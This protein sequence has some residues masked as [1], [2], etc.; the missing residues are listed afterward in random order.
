MT[1]R[2]LVVDDVSAN[3][4]LLKVKLENEYFT[5]ATASSGM[6]ALEAAA[7]GKPDIILLDVMMPGMDGF[8]T[9]CRLKAN[10]DTAHI[11]VIMVTALSEQEYRVRGL[12]AGADDFLTKPVDTLALIA[13]VRSLVRI[14]QMMD[15]LRV[16][17]STSRELG[18][19]RDAAEQPLEIGNG[20]VLLVS[21]AA[22]KAA[23][24]A[25][26]IGSDTVVQIEADGAKT[27]GVASAGSFDVIV[28]DA[29]S[30]GFDGLRLC[31][32]LRGNDAT[33]HVPI[34]LIISGS[35]RDRLVRA[36]EIGVF[37]YVLE[38]VD[39]HEFLARTR[40]QIKR[41][42]Y[43][44][45][46]RDSYHRSVELAITDELTG[47]FNRHYLKSHMGELMRRSADGHSVAVAILDIDFFKKI[48]DTYGHMA[49]D[50]I[51]QA[52]AREIGRNIRGVDL[53][54]RLGGEEFVVVMPD[55]GL[56]DAQ[57]VADRLCQAMSRAPFPVKEV[58]A[59][60][61]VTC[62]IGVAVGKPGDRFE[63][64]LE[65][66][67]Q[68]LYRAK[69]TGRNRV[70]IAPADSAAASGTASGAAAAEGDSP[71]NIAAG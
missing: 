60:I 52:F 10:P 46:L 1:A 2:V 39:H 35:D 21:E 34:L 20:R 40:A 53:A 70:V 54:C 32:E 23:E 43:Q 69:E 56:A 28:V 11:P 64:L 37:D 5:V 44:D 29:E 51:L 27:V 50:Q 62:S 15:E 17:E 66:A 59:P 68:A 16:R 42:R 14:K 33:R 8:E 22:A 12:V 45:R 63:D 65:Q 41:K 13:R 57:R 67:D 47:L 7:E 9:C 24:L 30:K 58:A 19:I 4:K 55:T 26:Y 18:L 31:A 3:V 61:P 38:P 25:G 48:N 71:R 36:L 49:G 6:E